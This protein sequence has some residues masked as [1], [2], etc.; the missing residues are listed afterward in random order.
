MNI[1]SVLSLFKIGS[2]VHFN[3]GLQSVVRVNFRTNFKNLF[4][5][6]CSEKCKVLLLSYSAPTFLF[7]I[8]HCKKQFSS[9][10]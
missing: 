4:V 7:S 10:C 6:C 1:P 2:F 8:I 3:Q 9:V 5:L